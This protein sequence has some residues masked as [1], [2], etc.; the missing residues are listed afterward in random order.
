VRIFVSGTSSGLGLHISEELLSQGD[1]V[2]GI[3]RREFDVEIM[4]KSGQ[5]NFKYSQCDTTVYSQVKDTFEQMVESGFIPDIAIF[6]AGSATED[7][8]GND[9]SVDMLRKNVEVNLLGV[10]SWVELLTPHF[11]GRNRGTFAGISSMSTFRENRRRRIGYSASKLALNKCF[12]NLRLEYS[13]RGVDFVI[14]NMGRMT[15]R[16]GLIG[17]SYEKAAR[18][19]AKMLKSDRRPTVVNIPR[20]QFLLTRAAG[21][22]PE[23]LFRRYLMG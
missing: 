16:R 4:Q 11:L 22:I 20:S 12:E 5:E 9:F 1:N 2:W 19:I 10:L 6:C 3:G 17:V 7:I 15:Q 18:L 13:D 8:A 21:L 23:R 14:C